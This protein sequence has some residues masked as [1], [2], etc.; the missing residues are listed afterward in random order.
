MWIIQVYENGTWRRYGSPSKDFHGLYEQ[1]KKFAEVGRKARVA[2][3][4][5]T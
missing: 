2:R 4:E 3:Y 5:N 1:C